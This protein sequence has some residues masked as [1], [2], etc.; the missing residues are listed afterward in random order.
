MTDNRVGWGIQ[1][2]PNLQLHSSVLKDHGWYYVVEGWQEQRGV[3][4]GHVTMTLM[5]VDVVH[6][7]RS[8]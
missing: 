8:R 1:W 5:K 6:G 7:V 2:T 4:G 3:A